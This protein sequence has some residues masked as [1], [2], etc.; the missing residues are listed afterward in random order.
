MRGLFIWIVLL[1]AAAF[2]AARI[3]APSEIAPSPAVPLAAIVAPPVNAAKQRVKMSPGRFVG[4]SIA[5]FV[6]STIAGRAS[7]GWWIVYQAP[8]G[9]FTNPEAICCKASDPMF[10]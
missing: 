6:C 8:A 1:R 9:E 4:F 10:W 5:Y 7:F 3:P 2:R